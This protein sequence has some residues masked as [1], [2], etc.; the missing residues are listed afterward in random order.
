VKTSG[1]FFEARAL[2]GEALSGLWQEAAELDRPGARTR[3]CVM[4]ALAVALAVLASMALRLDN[5]WWAGISAYVSI[6]ASSPASLKRGVLR[7]GGTIAGAAVGFLLAPWLAYDHA[8]C[9]LFMLALTTMGVFGMMV[10]AHGVAWLLAGITSLMVMFMSLDHP[11]AAL[12][13]AFYRL[14]EVTLGTTSALLVAWLLAKEDPG[15]AASPPPPGWRSM[16]GTSW[17]ALMHALR[18][19]VAVAM[20]PFLWNW[21]QLPSL[22]QVAVTV[23]AVMAV[24][25]L[26]D[27]SVNDRRK[28]AARGLHRLLGCLF[29]GCAGL[30]ALSL[31]I[32]E[33]APWLV[34]LSAGVWVAAHVQASARGVGYA[35]TQGAVVFIMTLVQNG[36]PPASILPGIDRFAGIAC[37][38]VILLAI[39]FLLAPPRRPSVAPANA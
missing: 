16:F 24:P 19:G 38:L 39:S 5:P 3:L 27:D 25:A 22:T 14:F 17:P 13:I 26:S 34:V 10:S 32:S 29:G 2:V 12:S 7:I 35:G 1:A 36:G 9:F 20:L 37:G 23:A 4:S 18:S 33:L 11:S 8:A 30:A 28:I 21:L 31:S 6:Q 15:A